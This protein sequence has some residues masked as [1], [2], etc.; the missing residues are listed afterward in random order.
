MCCT[1]LDEYT[2]RVLLTNVLT[3]CGAGVVTNMQQRCTVITCILQASFTH[4][5]TLAYETTH[6]TETHF[7]SIVCI[8]NY[9][10]IYM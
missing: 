2:F 1:C 8:L 4:R 3:A 9:T 6:Y 7:S 10:Y 5:I